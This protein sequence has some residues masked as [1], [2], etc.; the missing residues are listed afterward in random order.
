M[1][2]GIE[3]ADSAL[4]ARARRR[5]GRDRDRMAGVRGSVR[6][7][8][9]ALGDAHAARDRRSQPARSRGRPRCRLHLR[10]RRARPSSRA[11]RGANAARVAPW[12]PSCSSE[13]RAPGFGRSR[14]S[15]PK[16]VCRCS[17]ARCSNTC[18]SGSPRPAS[19]AS[20]S[21]AATSRTPFRRCFG[22][23]ALGLALEY[24]VEPRADGHRR[25][26]PARS[27]GRISGTFLALNGDVLADAPLADLV[28]RI[29][30]GG[31]SATI[32]LS[33]VDGPESLRTRTHRRRRPVLAFLEKPEPE[34]IDTDL[35]NAGAYVLEPSVL[36]LDRGG[37]RGLDR[38]RDLP[39]P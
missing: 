30:S 3:L 23:R 18:S 24:V 7:R 10:G 2:R 34:E 21:A 17:A 15:E 31:A 27:R 8:L 9:A 29:E 39:L 25:R 38:A 12:T 6:G 14:S 4:E 33:P 35:I 22:E 28:A 5:C 19:R 1:P 16:P 20:S 37:P 32:A 13:G 26:H 11:S 36:D